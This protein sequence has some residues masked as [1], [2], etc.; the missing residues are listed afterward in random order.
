[1]SEP[2]IDLQAI[3]E[4]HV[5]FE[6][7]RLRR[8]G[9]RPLIVEQVGAMFAWLDEMPLRAL[10]DP[11]T[12]TDVALLV[13]RGP[14][15]PEVV[16]RVAESLVAG[17]EAVRASPATVGDLLSKDDAQRWAAALATMDHARSA[18]LEQVTT[19]RAYTRLVAHVVYQGVKSFVL[20]ENVLAKRIPGA[21]S[22]VRFGQ[23]SLGSAAPGLE[24]NID[25][26]LTAFVDATIADT[27]RDSRRFLDRM[28][29][30]QE[31]GEISDETWGRVADGPVAQAADLLTED[32]LSTL[33]A[34]VWGQWLQLR[35]EPLVEQVVGR[36]V[37]AFFDTH[38]ERPCGEL[39][40]EIGVTEAS[41]VDALVPLAGPAVEQAWQTGY[42]EQ[43]VR[44]R[45]WAFYSTLT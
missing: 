23:R 5:A 37:A 11:D 17:Q 41:V 28:A 27:V 34:L 38:G 33:V 12:V 8:E 18:L 26:Q 14:A 20:T 15:G 13:L 6:V 16:A 1:M 45:L 29:D 3:Y 22:L 36:A 7:D 24:G 35:D 43:Q 40:V 2:A 42:L 10:A 44:D 25:R 4:A 31:V 21:S 30:E 9:L 39:L 19:S 32:E